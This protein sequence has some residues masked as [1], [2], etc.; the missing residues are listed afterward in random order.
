MAGE[1]EIKRVDL[2]VQALLEGFHA[3]DHATIEIIEPNIT[4]TVIEPEKPTTVK[5]IYELT[6]G[7]ASKH[8][9]VRVVA[10][11]NVASK[12]PILHRREDGTLVI[13]GDLKHVVANVPADQI[14]EVASDVKPIQT[15]AGSV[16]SL[17]DITSQGRPV[18]VAGFKAIELSGDPPET[19]NNLQF[20]LPDHLRV[21]ERLQKRRQN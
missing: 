19:F 2:D 5:H 9:Q 16:L 8:E 7:G 1:R 15:G 17:K 11:R 14:V 21:N 18:Y 3:V 13:T 6:P 20:K 4:D 10:V 12:N